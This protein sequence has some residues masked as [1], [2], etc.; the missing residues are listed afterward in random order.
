MSAPTAHTAPVVARTPDE[1][2]RALADAGRVALVPTMG[3]LHEGHRSLMRIAREAADTV[4]VSV[5]VNPLQFGPNEDFDRYPRD[6]PADTAV[7][8]AEGV[9]VV[10]APETETMYPTGRPVV[11]IDAGL[12]GERLEGSSRPGHFTGVLTVVG[13]LFHLVRPDLAVFGEKDA[14]QIALIRRM[15]ADLDLPVEIVGAPILRDADGLASSSR[16]VYLS[17]GERA[18]AL[19]LSR[20]LAAA[21][22]AAAGGPAAAR[23]AATAVLE[24]A[25]EGAPPVD[26]DYLA[27]IDPATFAEIADDHRGGAILALAAR[28]GTTRLI[29][30]T[31]IVF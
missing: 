27:L 30:N 9:D 13:K 16:N 4:V 3:A 17:T 5:F 22:A 11:T 31:S 14:Q 20:S 26:L 28:V 2:R 21:R 24:E 12:M 19:S 15:V 29:D 10:F 8:A 7:C 1:L 25:A 6:L 23:G 18:A